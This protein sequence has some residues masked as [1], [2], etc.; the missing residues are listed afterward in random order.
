MVNRMMASSV[1]AGGRSL[2]VGHSGGWDG[3][4]RPAGSR[5]VVTKASMAPVEET[6]SGGLDKGERQP[7]WTGDTV[8]SRVVNVAISFPPLFSVMKLGARSAIKGTAEKRSVPWDNNVQTLQKSKE[9]YEIKEEIE[10]PSITYPDYYTKPFHGY[11]EGNLNWL[12]AFEV[13]PATDAMALRVWKNEVDLSPLDAQNRLRRG[14]FDAVHDFVEVHSLDRNPR[15]ILDIGCS[16]GYSTRW[17]AAEYPEADVTGIDL[18]PYFLAVAEFRERQRDSFG[19]DQMIFPGPNNKGCQDRKRIKYLHAN[20]E[21]TG[22]ESNSFDF[23]SVQFVMHELPGR[24]IE[25]LITECRRLLRPGG[26]LALADNN[27][28]SKVIQ[29]LPPV[30]FTLMKSTEPWSDEYYQYDVEAAMRNIGFDGVVTKESDPRHR[31]LLGYLP[32]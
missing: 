29:N 3:T 24:A 23:I 30:L 20:M 6:A 25:G 28:R 26:I 9:V 2:R 16:T 31:V 22:L 14:I 19:N 18:S 21:S 17:L 11:D 13:E 5:F 1:S 12:A 4:R 10:N 8:L 15:D 27:P 7:K 32:K